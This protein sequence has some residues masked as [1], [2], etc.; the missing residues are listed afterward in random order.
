MRGALI[1]QGLILL[2]ILI[3]AASSIYNALQTKK[4]ELSINSRMTELLRVTREAA[5]GKGVEAGR[6]KSH[7][8]KNDDDH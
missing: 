1:V 6:M 2:G 4:V 8:T 3:N 5:H 7:E